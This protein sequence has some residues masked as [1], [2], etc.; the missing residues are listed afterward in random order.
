MK[1]KTNQIK[2][3]CN[4][5][6]CDLI[7]G[8][9]LARG[10]HNESYLIKTKKKNYILKVENNPG[11][12]KREYKMLAG[13][14]EGLAPKVYFFDSSRKIIPKPYL[15]EEFL[16][17]KNPPKKA[18][19]GFIIQMAKWYKKL[20]SI[21]S[22]KIPNDEKKRIYSLFY[23]FESNYKKFEKNKTMLDK[24]LGKEI[25][26]KFKRA[27]E[28][29][30]QND[31]I[32]SNIINFSLNHNDPSKENVFINKKKIRLIDWEFSGFGIPERDILTFFRQYKL[33]KNQKNLFLKSYK[34]PTKSIKKLNVLF[35]ILL[36]S[37]INY[38]IN[39]LNSVKEG[40][41]SSK[42]Q[43]TNESSLNKRILE[44]F[45]MFKIAL[46]EID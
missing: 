23:W 35:L 44:I 20:H 45:C 21:K 7:S 8:R 43:N 13:L 16:K 10:S 31:K 41:I 17:G 15:I 32:F 33:N 1:L 27:L 36:A 39:R 24:K 25:S 14:K 40:K 3:I 4:K 22:L 19:K 30:K 37:D 29:C 34:Y 42:Q 5:L 2:I 38:L 9:L 46:K 11:Y 28:I 26:D 6:K 18:N 12:V